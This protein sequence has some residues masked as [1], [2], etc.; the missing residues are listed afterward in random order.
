MVGKDSL[1]NDYPWTM[2]YYLVLQPDGALEYLFPTFY[3]SVVNVADEADSK[4][5]QVFTRC[6]KLIHD[7][8]Q[9]YVVDKDE[10]VK[11]KKSIEEFCIDEIHGNPGLKAHGCKKLGI[12]TLG[13]LLTVSITDIL[14]RGGWALKSFNTFF[15][16]WVGSFPASV[17]TA[18][19][20]AGW[21]Q[22][23]Y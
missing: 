1:F 21:Q 7:I 14:M 22:V 17:R 15:D 8:S 13:D 18:K 10:V 20:I 11:I 19:M 6:F 23:R 16:Y 12:Q 4:V 2:A 5:A 9:K 3:D